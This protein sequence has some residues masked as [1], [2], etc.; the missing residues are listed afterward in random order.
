MEYNILFTYI[1]IENCRGLKL[2]IYDHEKTK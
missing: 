2:K 1:Y